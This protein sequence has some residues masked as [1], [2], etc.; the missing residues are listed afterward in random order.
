MYTY[1]HMQV[2]KRQLRKTEMREF[3]QVEQTQ[4]VCE[5][6]WLSSGSG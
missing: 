6:R 5:L 4:N 1:A 2:I 3:V